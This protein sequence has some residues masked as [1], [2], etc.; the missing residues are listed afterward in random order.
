MKALLIALVSAFLVACAAPPQP[1]ATP[2]GRPEKTFTGLTKKQVTDAIVASA[3]SRGSQVKSVSE[4]SVV[5]ARRAENTAA[6]IL[7]GSRY[8]SVP[9]ARVTL[10]LVDV[11][12]GVQVYGRGEMVTNPGS[13]YEK[14]TPLPGGDAEIQKS[15]DDLAR[16]MGQ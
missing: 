13:G 10:N 14:V 16:R 7:F 12:G 5:L 6:Q 3:L 11:P 1:L 8:D 15:L 2:T 9:E 4:Y